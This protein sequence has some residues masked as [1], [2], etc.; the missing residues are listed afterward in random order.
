MKLLQLLPIGNV[1]D[2]LL[3]HLRSGMAETFHVSCKVLPVRLDPE[4]AYHG[5][6]QQYHSSE[7]LHRMQSLLTTDTWRILGVAA[8]DLYIP[9]L[10]FVFGE[11]QMGG[12]CALV[13][14]HRLR[15]EFYGLPPDP[16]L[17]QQRV[18]KESVHEVGH[19]LSLT[20]C[21]DYSCAMAPSHAV[22]WIDLK[23]GTLCASCRA[24]T[25]PIPPVASGRWF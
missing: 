19:T 16:E 17:Y 5:E 4:F 23:E 10:T 1:D 22:E 24:A 7:I 18:I 6:R 20:H 25:T 3:R 9:I 11:A 2:G 8:V 21:Q 14:A 15:Q 12:P 13:S